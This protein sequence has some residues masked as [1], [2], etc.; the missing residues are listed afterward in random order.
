MWLKFVR[1]GVVDTR[2]GLV[3]DGCDKSSSAT[4][5]ASCQKA[6]SDGPVVQR[7]IDLNENSLSVMKI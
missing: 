7:N 6:V 2:D 5:K 4:G 3:I 1:S